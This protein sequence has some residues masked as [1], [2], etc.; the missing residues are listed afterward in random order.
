MDGLKSGMYPEGPIL[1][2]ACLWGRCEITASGGLRGGMACG[3][4]IVL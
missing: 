2:V 1:K 4:F 3:K